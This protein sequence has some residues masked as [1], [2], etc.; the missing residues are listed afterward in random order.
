MIHI[1]ETIIVEGKFDKERVKRLCDAPIICTGGFQVFRSKELMNTIRH[2]AATTGI[3]MLTDSDQA[4]FKIRSYI[5]S[6]IGDKGTVKHAYIPS[7]QGKE[8]RKDKPGKEGILG[9]EGM[10]DSVLK[11][12][13]RRLAT[14]DCGSVPE[15]I[16]TKAELYSDGLSG[17]PDSL[18]LRRKVLKEL[19]LPVRLSP[20]AMIEIINKSN[21]YDEY[22]HALKIH[23]TDKESQ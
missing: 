22:K 6:C 11:D 5:K 8:K 10:D 4:G 21:M 20:N 19:N 7:V 14:D 13:L 3:I 2:L 17:K 12:I 9:V 15:H 16:L 18:N 23:K 1:K